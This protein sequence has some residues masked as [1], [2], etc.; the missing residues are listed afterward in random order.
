M[1]PKKIVFWDWNGTLLDDVEF[2]CGCLNW[3][4]EQHGYPQRYDLAA[5][6]EVFGFPIEAYYQRAGFDFSRH[7]YPVLARRFM[8]HYN[9]GMDCCAPFAQAADT[10]SALA[11]Q[12]WSQVVLSASRQDYLI[13][14]VSQRGLAGYFTELLG[15]QDIYG[16]SKVQRGLTWLQSLD[17]PPERCV[18]VG[19]TIHDAEVAKAL[20][21]QC[22]LYTGGHQSRGRLAAVCPHVIDRLDALPALLAQ[23]E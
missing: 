7:P 5:Y 13:E 15:L 8:D 9:A 14:Q 2:T 21:A 10:L 23:P 18:M 4:L 3:L 22:V 20:G 19:D 11:Q 6:R 16:A 12:G 1:Q 17:I